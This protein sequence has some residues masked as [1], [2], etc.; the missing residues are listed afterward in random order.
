MNWLLPDSQPKARKGMGGENGN[1]K[2]A[3][4]KQLACVCVRVS[5]CASLCL[6]MRV[7]LS[8][9][10]CLSVSVRVLTLAATVPRL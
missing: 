4:Q 6:C 7:S 5:V 9:R 10:A 2:N 1:E 3:V 8:V